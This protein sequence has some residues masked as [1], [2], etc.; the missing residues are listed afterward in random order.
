MFYGDKSKGRSEMI[1]ETVTTPFKPQLTEEEAEKRAHLFKALASPARWLILS[2]LVDHG[3]QICVEDISRSLPWQQPTISH[4]LSELQ[5]EGFVG[6]RRYGT[7]KYYYI[8]N[9]TVEQIVE[10]IRG[11]GGRTAIA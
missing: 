4:H 8:Q 6:H 5:E 2:L 3:G 10:I 7:F 9:D 11:I 1:Q